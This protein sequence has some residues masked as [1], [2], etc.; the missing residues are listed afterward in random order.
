M[1]VDICASRRK[2]SLSKNK[3][4]ASLQSLTSK[5]L[6]RIKEIN[7]KPLLGFFFFDLKTPHDATSIYIYIFN[8]YKFCIL[9]YKNKQKITIQ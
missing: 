7:I 6:N 3:A 8:R 9:K 2:R 4:L 1:P 5:H